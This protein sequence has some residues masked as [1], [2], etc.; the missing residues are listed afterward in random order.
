MISIHWMTAKVPVLKKQNEVMFADC[1][2]IIVKGTI[3]VWLSF[4][5]GAKDIQNKFEISKYLFNSLKLKN[6]QYLPQRQ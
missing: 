2:F 1:A 5:C 6:I 3:L 4:S